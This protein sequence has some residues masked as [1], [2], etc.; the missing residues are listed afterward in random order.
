MIA[1][2]PT[3]IFL[4]CLSRL[5][6]CHSRGSGNPEKDEMRVKRAYRIYKG[7]YKIRSGGD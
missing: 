3:F 4:S 7:K 2:L 5:Q 1:K 6:K